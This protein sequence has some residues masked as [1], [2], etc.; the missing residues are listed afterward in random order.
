MFLL[1]IATHYY[2]V[3]YIII[4]AESPIN[5]ELYTLTTLT[6]LDILYYSFFIGVLKLIYIIYLFC[7]FKRSERRFPQIYEISTVD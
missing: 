3:F 5:T 6:T 4:Y 2:T 7:C 1:H